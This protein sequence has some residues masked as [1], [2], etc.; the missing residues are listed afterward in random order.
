MNGSLGARANRRLLFEQSHPRRHS[1]E[2]EAEVLSIIAAQFQAING[3]AR[4]QLRE[5]QNSGLSEKRSI[6]E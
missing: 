3:S 5:T 6:S 4:T 2:D 1:K